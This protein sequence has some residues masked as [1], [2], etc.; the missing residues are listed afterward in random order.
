MINNIMTS[1]FDTEISR[2][3]E[4][5]TAPGANTNTA[6]QPASSSDPAVQQAQKNLKQATITATQKELDNLRSSK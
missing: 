5:L 4:E 6:Q 3:M 2:I 1:K